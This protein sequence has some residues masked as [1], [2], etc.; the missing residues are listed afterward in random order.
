VT[1]AASLTSADVVHLE[2]ARQLARRGWGHVSPNPLVGCVIVGRDGLVG[3]GYHRVFGGP[4]AEI[5]ALDEAGSRAEGATVY[6]TLEPCNHHG[7][8]P[9]CAQ[10]LLATGIR[11]V[12]FG[13]RDPGAESG[14]GAETLRAGGVEVSGPVWSEREGRAENPAFFHTARHASPFVALKLAMSLDG[15]IAARPGERTRVTGP[16]AESEVHR[17]RT[18]FDAVM[19]GAGTILTDDPLLTPRLG[20]PGRSAPRR[21]V[22]DSEGSLPSDAALF[23]DRDRAPIHVFVRHEVSEAALERLEAAGAHVHPVRRAEAGLALDE[24][25]AVC[26]DL[27]IRSIFCEGGA[28]VA[29]S[30]LREGRVHRLYLFVAPKTF[31]ASGVRAFPDDA[32]ALVWDG[33]EPAFVPTLHGRDALLVLDRQEAS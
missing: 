29:G 31:G 1:H 30:L 12:V 13:A 10:A 16:E 22:L 23:R 11:R 4:H 14:G 27:G 3:E 21:I 6:V 19:A 2:R 33:F 24:V 18:G 8:T 32:G 7:K 15:C 20:E 28:R 25:L 26:W 17:L 9:P 5:V